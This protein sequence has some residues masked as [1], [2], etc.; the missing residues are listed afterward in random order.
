MSPE[1][2]HTHTDGHFTELCLLWNVTNKDWWI[3]S[4]LGIGMVGIMKSFEQNSCMPIPVWTLVLLVDEQRTK[5]RNCWMCI[6][7]PLSVMCLPCFDA[8]GSV[9]G[10]ASGP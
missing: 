4:S 2:R 5:L 9:A 7:L 6:I 10:R 8:V 3:E 1:H